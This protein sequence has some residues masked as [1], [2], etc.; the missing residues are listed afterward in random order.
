MKLGY[1]GPNTNSEIAAQAY[2]AKIAG[3]EIQSYTCMDYVFRALE[4]K[5]VNRIIIPVKNSITGDI[6]YKRYAERENLRKIDEISI[7]IAHC[8]AAKT[9]DVRFIASHPEVLRQCAEYLDKK[10]PYLPRIEVEST[11]E[12][13][14]MASLGWGIGAIANLETCLF[15]GIRIADRNLVKNNF[16]TFWVLG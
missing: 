14:K 4:S 3:L 8:L 12:A 7:K 2:A 5:E 1:L 13:A 10:C 6:E 16:S 15:Y 9:R 11:N